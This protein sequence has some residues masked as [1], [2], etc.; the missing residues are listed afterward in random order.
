MTQLCQYI[1]SNGHTMCIGRQFYS[2]AIFLSFIGIWHKLV[3][4]V[5]TSRKELPNMLQR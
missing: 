4:T 5:V 2:L 1:K 3:G